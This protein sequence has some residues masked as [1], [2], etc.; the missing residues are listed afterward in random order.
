MLVLARF[1]KLIIFFVLCCFAVA[2]WSL[3]I[4]N[5]ITIVIWSSAISQRNDVEL[6]DYDGLDGLSAVS[7]SGC[8]IPT[9]HPF[10]PI[11]RPFIHKVDL[12]MLI[13]KCGKLPPLTYQTTDDRVVIDRNVFS[14]YGIENAS[15]LTCHTT[16]ILTDF[17][18]THKDAYRYAEQN[19]SMDVGVGSAKVTEDQ[20]RVEC[21]YDGALIYRDFYATI[22]VRP[23]LEAESESRYGDV[24]ARDPPDSDRL[25]VLILTVDSV[26]RVNVH[27]HMPRTAEYLTNEMRAVEMFGYNK[28]GDNTFP[29]IST[30]LMGMSGDEVNKKC[31]K[32]ENL[33]RCPFIWKE[34]S[35]RGYR[36]AFAEDSVIISAFSPIKPGFVDKPTDYYLRPTMLAEHQSVPRTPWN[37]DDYYCFAKRIQVPVLLTYARDFAARMSHRPHFG[38]FHTSGLTHDDMN[39]AQLVDPMIESFLRE[40][41]VADRFNNTLLI[42]M[43]DHGARFGPIRETYIGKLEE[44]LPF[45]YLVLPPWFADKHSAAARNLRTNAG[46]LVSSY[47]IH[48]TLVDVLNARYNRSRWT[49]KS[50]SDVPDRVSLFEEIPVTRTCSQANIPEHYCACQTIEVIG[51]DSREAMIAA[52]DVI[53]RVNELT[54]GERRQCAEYALDYVAKIYR[55]RPTSAF[56]HD[57]RNITAFVTDYT[58]TVSAVPGWA[59]FEGTVRFQKNLSIGVIGDVSRIDR[60][61][62]TSACVANDAILRKYCWCTCPVTTGPSAP[63]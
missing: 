52:A 6:T 36:T 20:L 44:S 17:N 23:E 13:D 28:L 19:R 29:I 62:L 25:S 7:T 12:S 34:F 39:W 48:E 60:Y 37:Q 18:G 35:R 32:N 57:K 41:H 11:V 8:R 27:R 55:S 63:T 4:S 56:S 59:R 45:L 50:S 2:W 1:K 3:V 51:N 47:D 42:L 5:D 14:L 49:P 15:L 40:G 61:G 24:K 46:R 21:R 43:S 33:D 22:Q 31:R 54:L 16:A 38:Y 26:S 30:I 10:D 53:A 58:V 9:I